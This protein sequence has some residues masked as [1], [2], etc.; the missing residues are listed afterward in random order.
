MPN[1]CFGQGLQAENGKREH[2]HFIL[3]IQTGLNIKFQLKLTIV[4]KKEISG[5]KEKK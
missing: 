4:P 5:L 3:H 2:H 1:R